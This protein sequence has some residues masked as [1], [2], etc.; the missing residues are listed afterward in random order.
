[1]Q[2][3]KTHLAEKSVRRKNNVQTK[4]Y[5]Q[6]PACFNLALLTHFADPAP[7]HAKSPIH[8]K[9]DQT[10]IRVVIAKNCA[11]HVME[12]AGKLHVNVAAFAAMLRHRATSE[13]RRLVIW[14]ARPA[15]LPMKVPTPNCYRR[16]AKA[17]H[18][19]A[20]ELRKPS[21]CR[22]AEN[23]QSNDCPWRKSVR[24]PRYVHA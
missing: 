18:A 10:K 5:L 1:M 11:D 15:A 9:R 23:S 4:P 21:D 8:S 14:T 2:C 3:G 13:A 7:L 20:P 12:K 19:C 16:F 17:L 22:E 6:T 24:V